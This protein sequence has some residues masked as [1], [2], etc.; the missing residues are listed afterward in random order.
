MIKGDEI[1]NDYKVPAAIEAYERQKQM[2]ALMMTLYGTPQTVALNQRLEQ[3]NIPTTS[4]G[5]GISAA[6]DGAR[7]PYL[8]PIAATYW[9]QGAAAV[10]FAKDQLG[11]SLKGKKIAYVYYD[12]P[13]GKE[14]MPILDALQKTEGSSMRTF[15]VPPPGVE[16]GAQILDITQRYHPDFIIA[17]LFG[18][19]PSVLIKGL[20]GAGYPLKQGD[21]PGLGLGR[22]RHQGGRRLGRRRGL[23][24]AAIR[25][26][27]RRLSGP[28]GNQGDVQ[29]GRQGP[30]EGNGRH[31]RLQ[32]RPAAGGDPGPGDDQRAED[33]RRPEADRPSRSRRAWSRSTTSPWAVSC[34]RLKITPT[35]HEGGGWVRIFQVQDGKFVAA[36]DWFQRLSRRRGERDQDRRSRLARMPAGRPIAASADRGDQV[37]MLAV[38]NIEVVYDGVILVLKGVSL[39]VEEGRITTLL[40]ANGAGKTTTL[41]AISGLLHSERGQITKGTVELDGARIDR[42]PPHDVVKRGVVQVFEGQARLREFDGRGEPYRRRP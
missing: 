19:S 29:E 15:A 17:H 33:Q 34:R 39:G 41:K 27:R 42:L 35:D 6:A 23:Q 37:A 14:P 25:R 28:P 7:Y 30:A 5:F 13:A 10:K 11:G 24:H 12:N 26:R 40:G 21:R 31:G 8:F 32:P 2:G 20:K 36:T 18:R 4:P 1:D 16:L 22:G 38:N 3:D 9:S